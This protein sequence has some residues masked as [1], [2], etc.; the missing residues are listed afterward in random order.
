MEEE[1]PAHELVSGKEANRHERA[2]EYT[3]ENETCEGKI[4]DWGRQGT[5]FGRL[6]IP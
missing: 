3:E 4:L 2:T 6:I 5:I 1:V